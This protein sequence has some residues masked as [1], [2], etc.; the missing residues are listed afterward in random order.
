[1]TPNPSPDSTPHLDISRKAMTFGAWALALLVLASSWAALANQWVQDDIFIILSNQAV[2]SLHE[3]WRFF[4]AA[5]WPEPFPPDLY[6]PITTILFAIQWA[7][8][9]GAPVTFRVVSILL[10]LASTL[11]CWTLARRLLPPWPAW[12]AA[13]LFA[14]H[15]VHVEAV[16]VAVNQSELIVAGVAFVVATVWIDRRRAGKPATGPWGLALLTAWSVT[17]LVKENA[18]VLPILLVAVELTVLKCPSVT[19]L[20][21]A[22]WYRLGAATIAVVAVMVAIRSAVLPDTRGSFVAE[23]LQGL[24]LSG[25]GLTMLAVV[26][27]WF[28]LLAW[29]RSLQADYSPGEITAASGFGPAQ[30]AGAG[31]LALATL[32]L[33]ATWRKQPVIAFGVLWLGIALGPVHNVLVPTGIVLAERTLFLGSAGF[34]IGTAAIVEAVRGSS[35]HRMWLDRL[36]LLALGVLLTCGILR[37]S[38]RQQIWRDLPTF[39]T[40]LLIDA[41]LSYRAH[42]TYAQMLAKVDDLAGAEVHFRRS[43]ELFPNSWVVR[44]ELADRYR[45][46]GHCWPAVEQYQLVLGLNPYHTAARGSLVACQFFLGLYDEARA[47]AVEGTLLGREMVSFA[48]YVAVA[49][50]AI[51][52]KAAPGTVRLPPPVRT[53][54]G[55]GDRQ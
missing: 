44:A 49:D 18:A 55:E 4:L 10:Y 48:R 42:Y 38:S 34:L 54:S 24:S 47:A 17:L 6:R 37:S 27:E 11:A 20:R 15:P 7:V 51:A 46:G 21:R 26:P 22:D 52:A 33:I 40:Q 5:Y 31:L 16:A 45:L 53:T 32:I 3:P 50:S 9:G 8:G 23:G 39:A 25:R 36:I 1:M 12:S 41:P 19:P 14:V 13:A 35:G 43:I 2:H 28:R 29:P 30:A